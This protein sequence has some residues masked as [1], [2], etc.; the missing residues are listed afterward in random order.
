M[1][2]A[3]PTNLAPVA[4]VA[5]TRDTTGGRFS[6]RAVNVEVKATARLAYAADGH[7]P[8]AE[9][10]DHSYRV[11]ATDTKS[12]VVVEGACG[13]TDDVPGLNAVRSAPNRATSALVP[14][15]TFKGVFSGAAKATKR[16]R[17]RPELRQVFVSL[18][19]EVATFGHTDAETEQVQAT[20]LVSG[21]FPPAATFID[22]TRRKPTRATFSVDPKRLADMLKTL[23][24]FCD[25]DTM[26]VDVEVRGENSPIVLTVS[27]PTQ[28]VTGLVMPLSD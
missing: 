19:P 24:S 18:S 2:I 4:D 28:K 8:P 3:L 13:T 15:A 12:L 22:D 26:R 10:T 1:M 7:G 25:G 5:D 17:N 11:S 27:T 9:E 20:P 6:L 23:A 16:L 14:L 21:R